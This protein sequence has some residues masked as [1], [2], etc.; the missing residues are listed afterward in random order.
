MNPIQEIY[1]ETEIFFET[2]A[3][4]REIFSH[5]V[6]KPLAFD[7]ETT[8]LDFGVPSMFYI[9]DT[10]QIEVSNPTAFGISV[11]LLYE[12]KLK[13]FWG[14]AGTPLFDA[15]VEL[16][17]QPRR[18]VAHNARYDIR[19]L[20]GQGLVLPGPFDCTLTMSRI[21][22]DNRMKHSLQSLVEVICPEMSDWEVE[23]KSQM[24]KIKGFWT[25]KRKKEG[26]PKVK[27]YANYS[28]IP[29]EVMRKY[30]CFDVF[31]TYILWMKYRPIIRE[32]HKEVYSRE[33]DVMLAA[34]DI[35][36]HGLLFNRRRAKKEIKVLNKKS[37][38]LVK[39]IQKYLGKSTNPESYK[40]L[41]AGMLAYGFKDKQ[42][43][44]K[45]KVS[46]CKEALE[47]VT[48]SRTASVKQIKICT[49]L[50]NLRSARTLASRYLI[51]LTKR[52]SYNHGIVYCSINSADTRTSRMSIS[53]PS[54]QNI[55]RPESGT[56]G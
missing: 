22:N 31:F 42:L 16:L 33:I 25:R 28:F 55:P 35:E 2:S 39:S 21:I 8:G 23:V 41:L 24:K 7:T 54:L 34:V 37:E 15:L 49:L 32:I 56:D 40:Q 50:L 51:P 5:G 20:R 38:L 18:K 3:R 4:Q 10:C 47:R 26:L 14:R 52:A 45:G 17:N 30:A 11:C 29:E 27:D 12:G 44:H 13:L 43:I 53:S 36:N 9:N 48:L 19:I 1:N 6:N 46:T